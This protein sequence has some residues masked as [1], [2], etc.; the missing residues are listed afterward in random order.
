MKFVIAYQSS[1]IDNLKSTLAQVKSFLRSPAPPGGFALPANDLRPNPV[2]A[3]HRTFN[4]WETRSPA[5]TQRIFMEVC[6]KSGETSKYPSRR[7][8][9]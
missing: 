2:V 1:L 9:V 4:Q 8:P 3:Y 5:K 6:G 7:V